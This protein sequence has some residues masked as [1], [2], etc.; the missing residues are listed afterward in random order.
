MCADD[1]R[2]RGKRERIV[3]PWPLGS[4]PHDIMINVGKGLAHALIVKSIDISGDGFGT[5]YADAVEGSHL[6]SPVGIADVVVNKCAWSVKTVKSKNPFKTKKIRLISGRNSPTY[7]SGIT[8]LLD[9]IQATGNSVLSIWNGRLDEVLLEYG[10]LRVVVLVRNMDKREFLMFEQSATHFPLGDYEWRLNKKGNLE[11]YDIASEKH[12]F[13]W[14]PHGSQFTIIKH[15]PGSA[16][17]FRI[18]EICTTLDRDMILDLVDFSS[19]WIEII[20]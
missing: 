8:N 1:V 15:I 11:G 17:R 20:E 9:N 2:L 14:Q 6:A 12:C 5:I 18:K 4:F 13:T 10:V 7:S 16:V 19:D 3:S